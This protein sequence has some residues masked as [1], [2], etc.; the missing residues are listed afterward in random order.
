MLPEND[1]TCLAERGLK[2][3]AAQ[4]EL[5][6]IVEYLPPDNPTWRA[7]WQLYCHQRLAIKDEQ[8]L[9]ESDFVSL[10]M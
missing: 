7:Y 1:V 9:F 4:G 3:Q 2:Y 8:K 10:C 6:L 5:E